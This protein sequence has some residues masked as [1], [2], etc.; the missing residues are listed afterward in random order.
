MERIPINVNLGFAVEYDPE[1]QDVDRLS[2][3]LQEIVERNLLGCFEG[4]DHKDTV[5]NLTH[6][7]TETFTNLVEK[8]YEDD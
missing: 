4:I 1:Y 2:T 7:D 6:V 3:C 5:A 8:V